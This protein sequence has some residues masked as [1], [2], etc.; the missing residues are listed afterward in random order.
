[1]GSTI[2]T[3]VEVTYAR[4]RSESGAGSTPASAVVPGCTLRLEHRR[5]S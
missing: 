3:D 1:M 4:R 2:H 5:E